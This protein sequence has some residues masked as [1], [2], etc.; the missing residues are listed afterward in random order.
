MSAT[1]SPAI[2]PRCSFELPLE[3]RFC[4]Q[5]GK[6]VSAEET[7]ELPLDPA[8]AQVRAEEEELPAGMAQKPA[9]TMHRIER[10]PLG[11]APIPLLA[12]LAGGALLL[13]IVMF[14]A[15]GWI[16]G[17]GLLLVSAALFGLLV[18]GVRRQPESATAQVL[19]G[20]LVRGRDMSGFALRSGR[21]W[22]RTGVELSSLRWR[23]VRLQRELR[24]L[25][26]PLG[27]A[28]H[29]G[30]EER[31]AALK[32]EATLLQRQLDELGSREASLVSSAQSD[33]E[34]ERV[35]VQPTEVLTP[36]SRP[37]VRRDSR[38]RDSEP[39]LRR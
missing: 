1:N 26:I 29:H 20:L 11:V 23:R 5:C 21:T 33:L 17:F 34:R 7:A 22:G 14:A 10:R 27:E 38:R 24:S 3:A 15:V 19:G 9:A 13:A 2:C 36:V 32:S 8:L 39:A 25:F 28:V 31:A 18:A 35:P 16:P 4:P 12:G 6:Q 30:D 37:V